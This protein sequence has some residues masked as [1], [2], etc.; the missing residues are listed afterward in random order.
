MNRVFVQV[1]LGEENVKHTQVQVFC[2]F[3]PGTL[4]C[5]MEA[6]LHLKSCY[7][8]IPLLFYRLRCLGAYWVAL[9]EIILYSVLG[10]ILQLCAQPMRTMI[11]N[12]SSSP[13]RQ[14]LCSLNSP[15]GTILSLCY[16]AI[17]A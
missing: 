15:K 8:Y 16:Q 14:S 17:R 2:G 1:K 3:A 7:F 5:L 10:Y 12:L 4:S 6:S 13:G 9:T 11:V